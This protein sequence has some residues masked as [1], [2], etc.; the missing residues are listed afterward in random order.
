MGKFAYGDTRLDFPYRND[1]NIPIGMCTGI[2]QIPICIW[3]LWVMWSL[4]ANGDLCDPHMRMG[5]VSSDA[6][7]YFRSYLS[8]TYMSTF[9]KKSS[10]KILDWTESGPCTHTGIDLDPCMHTGIMCH[11]IPVCMRGSRSILVWLSGTRMMSPSFKLDVGNSLISFFV[12]ASAFFWT[13][14]VA[15]GQRD[16]RFGDMSWCSAL[17][18]PLLVFVTNEVTYWSPLPAFL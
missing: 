5:E 4:Y 16:P 11:A 15:F 8:F 17:N 7:R 13:F 3:G 2:A 10:Q 6:F 9:S 14:E 12:T 1:W 18:S